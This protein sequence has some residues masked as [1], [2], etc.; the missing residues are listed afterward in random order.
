MYSQTAQILAWLVVIV[1]AFV[2]VYVIFVLRDWDT[3]LKY[4]FVLAFIS[5]I[6]SIVI[7]GIILQKPSDLGAAIFFV[8]LFWGGI[9]AIFF[10][11]IGNAAKAMNVSLPRF[12]WNEM[13]HNNVGIFAAVLLG[14]LIGAS[15]WYLAY[16]ALFA[17]MVL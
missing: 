10:S 13:V 17:V 11:Q 12:I 14:L 1:A 8:T 15:T 16:C 2:H 5:F 4:P 3:A 6:Y 7:N 9:Y